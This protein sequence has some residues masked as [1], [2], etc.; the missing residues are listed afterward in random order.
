MSVRRAAFLT[1][2]LSVAAIAQTF[3]AVSIRPDNSGKGGGSIIGTGGADGRVTF[4]NI[5][6]R[7]CVAFAYGIAD[8]RDYELV[9]PGWLDNENFDIVATFRPGTVRPVILAMLQH[10]LAERFG[11]QVHYETKELQAYVMTVAKD[12]PKLKPH[13]SAEEGFFYSEDY[14]TFR[15]IDM[16][17]LSSR[18][19]GAFFHLDRPVVDRTG[20]KGSYDF[21][22]NWSAKDP[23][24]PSLFTAV[25]EQLGLHLATE[26]LPF[27]ILIVDNVNRAPTPN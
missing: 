13:T 15:A 27:R 7:D 17:G 5:S 14:V 9:S 22:L 12:G 2:I 19:S 1:L 21:T 25:E 10:M 16:A 23:N 6:L 8:G 18:F 4:D 20:L 11:L 26:K 24:G 3:D